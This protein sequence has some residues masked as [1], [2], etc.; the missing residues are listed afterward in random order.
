MQH[1]FPNTCNMVQK[2]WFYSS[3]APSAGARA[4]RRPRRNFRTHCMSLASGRARARYAFS[5]GR[6]EDLRSWHY[7]ACACACTCT[8]ACTCAC[9]GGAAAELGAV[10]DF[11][12]GRPIK[13]VSSCLSSETK[14]KPSFSNHLAAIVAAVVFS[15][16][17]NDLIAWSRAL[18]LSAVARSISRRGFESGDANQSLTKITQKIAHKQHRRA[19]RTVQVTRETLGTDR[20]SALSVGR[21][22]VLN[23]RMN[24]VEDLL[25]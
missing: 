14:T 21:G 17:L 22:A 4:H 15:R 7:C 11:L 18:A 9:G 20:V 3:H 13:Y 16:T 10:L 2:Y 25:A 24:G 23:V 19:S 6:K 1:R 12:L 8:C 5:S